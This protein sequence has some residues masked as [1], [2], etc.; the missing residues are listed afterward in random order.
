MSVYSQ[1]TGLVK[2]YGEAKDFLVQF[3]PNYQREI[4]GSVKQCLFGDYP[5]L[6]KLKA[7]GDKFPMTWLVPQLY[8]LSEYCG[9]RDKL[10]GAALEDCAFTIATEFQYLK[11][12]EVMLFL[13]RF[14]AGKYGRFYGSVD[15]LTITNAMHSFVKERH[16]AYLQHESEEREK[17]REQWAKEAV[18]R[19]EY[20]RMKA[21]GTLAKHLNS[22]K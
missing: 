17:E 11:V 21:D 15:P 13:H 8:N 5:T 16:Y 18:S 14:K 22:G 2:K 9:C 7:Y 20:L 19:E 6:G 3:N 1:K 4:C 10:K 12:S